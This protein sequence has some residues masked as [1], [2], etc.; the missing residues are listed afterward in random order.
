M[1]QRSGTPLGEVSNLHSDEV[2][3]I[4]VLIMP[5]RDCST[6]DSANAVRPIQRLPKLDMPGRVLVEVVTRPL[7]SFCLQN[8]DP[9]LQTGKRRKRSATPVPPRRLERRAGRAAQ[10]GLPQRSLPPATA[11]APS[12]VWEDSSGLISPEESIDVPLAGSQQGTHHAA[13]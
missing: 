4:I 9:T 10:R 11:V 6:A 7:S 12:G 1:S 13:Q 8:L 5:N 3:L 2:R